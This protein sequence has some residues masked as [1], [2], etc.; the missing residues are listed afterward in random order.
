LK[1]CCVKA[2]HKYALTYEGRSAFRLT[3]TVVHKNDI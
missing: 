3:I 2:S 1:A